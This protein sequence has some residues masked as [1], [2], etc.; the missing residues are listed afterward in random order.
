MSQYARLRTR[1][2]V[3]ARVARRRVRPDVATP[4]VKWAGGKSR[5]LDEIMLRRPLKVR[6]YFEP[7]VGGGAVFF[8]LAPAHSVISD[9]NPDLV[10]TYRCVAWHVEGVIRRLRNHRE[11]HSEQHYYATRSRWNLRKGRQ[12]DVDRAAMFIYMNKTCYNGLYRVNRKG[13]F[14]VPMGRYKDPQIFDPAA[15]RTASH[16]LQRATILEAGYQ[17]VLD[18]AGRGDF[19]Y[20]DP[21]YQPMS[22]TAN[23]TSYTAD[24]FSEDDQRELA[25]TARLLANK[26]C[27]VMVSN[28]DT[29]L[30]R[31][32][33]KGFEIASVTCN[34]Q[35]NS[36][37]SSRGA[38]GEVIV[39]GGF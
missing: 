13:L 18:D 28:S 8:R 29:P 31:E 35:I 34:R 39:T 11:K 17:H 3:T 14:N 25:R 1:P 6:R 4:I 32:I 26:S 37:A 20:F 5:L 12:S 10:N 19:V 21:P 16:A 36:R 33:Y 15:L 27:A 23:F 30:I 2:M 38:V 9:C 22:E 24:S 7:F